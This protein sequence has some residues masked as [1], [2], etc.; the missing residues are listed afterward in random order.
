MESAD[1]LSPGAYRSLADWYL[2]AKRRDAHERAAAAVYQTTSEYR[3]SQM[4]AAKLRPWQHGDGRLPTE[5]D[6]EVLR[7]FAVLFE[8][9]ATPQSYLHQLQQ[10]YQAI[11]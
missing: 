8:K 7:M 10:F 1:E 9:S 11:A 5:L 6:K 2:V 3:L 4:I